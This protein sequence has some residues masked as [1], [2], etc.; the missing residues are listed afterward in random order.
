M[1]RKAEAGLIITASV[2]A[3]LVFISFL[4]YTQI[5]TLQIQIGTLQS[6]NT[7][8]ESEVNQ[9]DQQAYSLQTQIS[10][11]ES[12][13]FSSDVE[14][15]HLE[16]QIFS[17][18]AEIDYLESQV[19]FLNT[20]IDHFESLVALY[21]NIPHGYYETNQFRNHANTITELEDFLAYEFELP[22]EYEKGVFDCSE[23]SAYLEWALEDA[24]FNA[25]IICGP[26]PWQPESGYHA[27]VIVYTERYTVA[28]EATILSGGFP[29]I[30]E[31][32][33]FGKAP[34]VVYSGDDYEY[35]Y[36]QG[37]D[38]RYKN[39]YQTI[40]DYSSSTEWNWWSVVDFP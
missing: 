26:T 38:E 24:G 16:N 34:G 33:L 6:E 14:I 12:Q 9:K 40:K 39:I 28:I 17:L 15:E 7:E 3:F 36:Y 22:T 31:Y 32:L 4:F 11:L 23:S 21:E 29:P 20:E 37:F 13:V 27:W 18:N 1:S 35:G 25:W 2:L 30:L 19:S 8:L 5:S 10:N